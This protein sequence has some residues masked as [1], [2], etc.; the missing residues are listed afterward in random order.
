[1]TEK[2]VEIVNLPVA[3]AAASLVAGDIDAA[4]VWEP[5]LSVAAKPGNRITEF[6]TAQ[7]FKLFTNPIIARGAFIKAHPKETAEFLKVLNRAGIWAKAN[8]EE[9]AKI[10]SDACGIDID[11]IKINLIK[12]GLT[13]D[14]S[15]DRIDALVLS[16]E[17]SLKYGLIAEKIDVA[18]RIDTS[19]LKAAGLQ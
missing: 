9:A 16:A 11:A 19:Y 2:D 3:D 17:Q 6:A 13:P 10:I 1:L 7:G 5:I 8:Q 14:L 15:Q 18:S 4:V 12:R